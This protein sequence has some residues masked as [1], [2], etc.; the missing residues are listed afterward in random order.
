MEVKKATWKLALRS[1]SG[2]EYAA[3]LDRRHHR[4][5]MQL[6]EGQ[7]SDQLCSNVSKLS[8]TEPHRN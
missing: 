2:R 1:P 7:F 6:L 5:V 4:A 3:R 8:V